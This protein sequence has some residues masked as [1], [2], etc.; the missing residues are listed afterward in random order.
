MTRTTPRSTR[1][2]SLLAL[3]GGLLAFPVLA[4]D[5]GGERQ[6]EEKPAQE[7]KAPKRKHWKAELGASAPGFTLRDLSGAEWKLSDHKGK[8]VVLEWFNPDC[9]IV[10]QAHGANGQLAT[11]GNDL[12]ATDDVVWVAINSGAPGRQGTGVERNQEAKKTWRMSY[13][14]LLDES[15]YV[16]RMYG[17]TT[18]P[19]MYVI[20]PAGKLRYVGGHGQLE[21]PSPVEAA[22][23]DVR[24]GR[25]VAEPKTKNFGCDVKYAHKAELA[26]TAP[27]FTLR[28]TEGNEHSLADQLGHV[29]VLEWFNPDCPIVQAAHDDGGTLE[30]YAQTAMD[31]GVKWFAINSNAPGT[32]GSGAER[33]QRAK[34]QWSLPHP[35]LLDPEGRTGRSYGATTTPHMYV[36]DARGVLVYMGGHDDRDGTNH[37]EKALADVLA[38]REVETPKTKNYGC[39]VKYRDAN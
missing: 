6:D 2:L 18:T 33:N 13:P 21:Q 31:R 16:G 4:Q 25:E 5:A 35:V 37:V 28:D 20:D 14:V 9:P 17:A 39:S 32:Q 23:E 11:L 12:D 3:L 7:E 1:T 15:G 38:G 30:G 10:N 22:V 36:I 27:Y 26:Q 29:V 8:I 34:E 19:H 24:A